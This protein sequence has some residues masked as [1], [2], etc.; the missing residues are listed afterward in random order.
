MSATLR[1]NPDRL[2][3]DLMHSAGIGATAEGGLN[4]LSLGADDARIR[5]WFKT[6]A[7]SLGGTV[8]TDRLGTQ[9]ALFAGTEERDPIAMGSHLDTQ[10]TGGRFD[11]VLGVLGGLTAVRAVRE[12]GTVTRHPLAVIN[13]TNEE[14]ARFAPAMLAS[15]VYAGAFSAEYALARADGAGA[16]VGQALADLGQVGE[17]DPGKPRLAA[18]FELHIEQGPILERENIDIGVVTGVQGIAWFDVTVTGAPAHAGS[19]PMDMRHDP[20]L[21]AAAMIQAIAAI[22]AADPATC[23]ATVGQIAARPGSRNTVA[24]T[25]TFSV[26]LRHPDAGRLAAMEAALRSAVA[27]PAAAQ[28]CVVVVEKIWY[29]PPVRFDAGC[30]R[31]VERA[32]T[33]LGASHRGM[34]SGAGHDAVYVARVAPT[35]M[36]FTPCSGGISHHPAESITPDEAALGEDV[37]LQAVLAYDSERP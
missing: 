4:R 21:A 10:P 15:G 35:A 34:V 18:Y 3:R 7:E 37:L 14:G 13:W 20:V 27:G 26:D 8:L 23:R 11:G 22:A 9:F 1:V 6:E 36:I 25:V 2:W 31:A 17:L 28:G 19:T 30:V 12:A 32:A 29:S 24:E 5:A 33:L 16:T